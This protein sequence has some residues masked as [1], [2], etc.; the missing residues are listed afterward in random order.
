MDRVFIISAFVVYL[1]AMLYIGWWGMKKSKG[2]EGYYVANRKCGKWLSVGTFTGS[3]ISAVAVIGYTGNGYAKGY[4]TLVNVLGCV[5]SFYCIY[6]LFTKVIKTRFDNMCTI[7]E[8]FQHLYG[9]KAML[10]I[11]AVVT[12]CLNIALL[13]NQVK[14][15]SLI[16]ANILGVDYTTAL[17]IIAA[18][19]IIYTVMGGMYS[20]VYTDL[21]QTV[22][23][24]VGVL[25]ALPFTLKMVGGFGTMQTSI[26]QISPSALDPIGVAG[27]PV[28][29]FSTL[30]SFSLGI[31]ASQYYLIRIYS[32]KNLGTAKFMIAASC[33][34]WTV[35]GV[36]LVIMGV[37][38]RVLIPD[39]ASSDSAIL[40]LADRL[41]LVVRTL[42][43]IGLACAI[44]STT[45]TVLLVAGTYLG[46]DLYRAINPKVSDDNTLKMTRICVCLV[47]IVSAVL[48]LNPPALILSLTTFTTSVSAGTFFA[49]MLLGFFWK[50][51]TKEAA[52]TSTILGGITAV[53]WQ[54]FSPIKIPAAFPAV[55]VSFIAAIVV[56]LW[57]PQNNRAK[58]PEPKFS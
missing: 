56:S 13:V 8:L 18:V 16:C 45:D 34:I 12:V 55:T 37:A 3:F 53:L 36:V 28:G 22:I 46:R 27:G 17:V 50:R 58:L 35:L 54:L 11:T 43:L 25:I 39:L 15:G 21:I 2:A 38:T 7:P 29:V 20:V 1:V 32:A 30:L 44:M 33:S 14:G 5:L 23:I 6:F 26:A 24:I 9:S 47:G 42:L 19:F 40:M 4:M 52:L 10:V 57:G 48:A 31:A 49:P 41:P 51:M